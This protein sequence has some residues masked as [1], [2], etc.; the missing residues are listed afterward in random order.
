LGYVNACLE[1]LDAEGVVHPRYKAPG[2]LTGRLAGDAGLNCFHPDTEI[3]TKRG[4]VP[5]LNVTKSDLIWSVNA[6]TLT[7]SWAP[8]ID[9]IQY[10]YKGN[11]YKF[12]NLQVTA[13]HRMA[14][15]GAAS[16]RHRY[17]GT[18]DASS[19]F[20]QQKLHMA[21][22]TFNKTSNRLYSEKEIW[23]ACMIQADGSKE[24]GRKTWQLGF[25]KQR[26]IDK[27][28]ELLNKKPYV[29]NQG[30]SRFNRIQFKSDLLCPKTKTLKLE[31]LSE[32]QADVFIEALRFWDSHSRHTKVKAF[33]YS[34]NIKTNIDEVQAY[35]TKSGYSVHLH[36]YNAYI[37][38]GVFQEI[39]KTKITKEYYKGKV[40]CVTVPDEHLLVR[41]KGYVY[42]SGNC[43]QLPK[44]RGYLECW[45]PRS[46]HVWVSIDHSSL[47]QVVLA[48]L[49]RDPTRSQDS[50]SWLQP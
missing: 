50:S 15:Y 47:E 35:L 25:R 12:K 30:T 13:N 21:T 10:D 28:I 8:P 6:Q 37:R 16:Q 44:S 20:K 41:S 17:L 31:T 4:W 11:L 7:G 40:G 3:L 39:H 36:N 18:W 27:A 24:S 19:L 5:I 1:H 29:C 22:C 42:V 14:W 9:V 33:Q 45:K 26:K 49:S 38:P 2:T 48:E 34:S 46:G 32:S 43:Q 23:I